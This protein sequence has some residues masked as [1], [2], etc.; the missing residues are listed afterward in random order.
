VNADD[1]AHLSGFTADGPVLLTCDRCGDGEVLGSAGQDVP[2]SDLAIWAR[3]HR[4]PGP[5]AEM[6]AREAVC[7]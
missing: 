5:S 7:A 4:C 1:L 3:D 2:L 6:P